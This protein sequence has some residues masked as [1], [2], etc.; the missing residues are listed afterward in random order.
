MLYSVLSTMLK[1]IVPISIPVISGALLKRFQKLDTRPLVTLYLYFLNPALI[2]ETLANADISYQDIYQ[3][4][5]FSLLNLILLWLVAAAA[6]RLLKLPADEQAGLTLVATFT[7]SVNYGLP[8]V[9]LAFGQL[10]LDKASVYVIGQ[11]IIV[12]T[13]GVYLAARSNFS[14]KQAVKSVFTLPSIYAAAAAILLRATGG[15]LPFGI[16]Q[17]VTMAAAAYSPVVLAILG[18]QMVGVAGVP[19]NSGSKLAF[20][21]GIAIRMLLSPAVALLAL[22]LL[23][24]DGILFAV[25]FILACMPAAVNAAA[26][27]EKFGAS[28]QTVSKCILWTTL[29]SFVT[30]PLLIVL[31]Q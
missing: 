3:T 31:L 7:N 5:G 28:P 8:L 18:A 26:L 2:L 13:V 30:L 29:A 9:L 16:A 19:M 21:S 14:M 17:G 4:L 1:V 23:Q 27:A 25:L 15:S 22:W 6:G 20:R 12:N 10:G 24:I 11:M